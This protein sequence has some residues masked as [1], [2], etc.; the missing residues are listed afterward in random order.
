MARPVSR[1]KA[2]FFW[3]HGA[4]WRCSE[5]LFFGWAGTSTYWH[6]HIK[7]HTHCGTSHSNGWDQLH[8]DGGAEGFLQNIEEFSVGLGPLSMFLSSANQALFSPMCL[9][10]QTRNNQIN[11]RPYMPNGRKPM[12]KEVGPG[13]GFPGTWKLTGSLF[14]G[15]PLTF[16][17]SAQGWVWQPGPQDGLCRVSCSAPSETQKL[18]R[19]RRKGFERRF[20]P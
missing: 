1:T 12:Q 5:L 18:A 11:G 3:T 8:T 9:N 6:W 10:F 2:P 20:S 19:H 7:T 13:M 16:E 14:G 17:E 15:E 4:C